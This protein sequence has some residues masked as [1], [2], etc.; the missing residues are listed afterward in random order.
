M[1]IIFPGG[2]RGVIQSAASLAVGIILLFYL[3]A[4]IFNLY[5]P[6]VPLDH[7]LPKKN[8]LY[9]LHDF[10]HCFRLLWR[11]P[12]GQVSLAVTTLLWG[13]GP[14]LRLI[15]LPWAALTLKLDTQSSPR[16]ADLPTLYS[17]AAKQLPTV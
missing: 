3:I 14:T 7:K 13:A 2:T 17:T 8:P 5:I 12:L 6:N 11:D 10:W 4:A 1:T 16:V 9:V 15:I